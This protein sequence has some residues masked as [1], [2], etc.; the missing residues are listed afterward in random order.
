ME[1]P[2]DKVC[3]VL[4]IVEEPLS[5]E[6]L[7]D[8]GEGD[9]GFADRLEDLQAVSPELVAINDCL[10]EKVRQMLDEIKPREA[11][12]IR[13]RFGIDA[14]SAQTLEEIGQQF[15]VTRERIRQIEAKALKK[16]AHPNRSGLLRDFLSP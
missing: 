2:E 7:M 13:L 1:I 8:D 14:P 3:K 16:L 10:G 11:E 12:V 15:D 4:K 6:T 5:V 9:E